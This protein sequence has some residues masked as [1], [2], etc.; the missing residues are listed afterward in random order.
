MNRIHPT[1]VIGPDVE[2][3]EGNVVGPYAV[4][5]GPAR[6][7]DGNWIGPHVVV[8]T[9]GEVRGAPHRAAW[10]DP[11]LDPA[12][13]GPAEDLGG[14]VIGNNNVL[15]EFA[16][17]QAPFVD[18]TRIG[19]DCYLMTK[20]HVPHDGVLGDRV[21]VACSVMI[22]GH[23]RIGDGA[24]LGL[25]SVLHQ[26]LVVGPGAMVG[27]GS[28]VTRP[29]PPFG[30]AYG[31]PARVRG[32]NGVGMRRSGI[33]DDVIDELASAYAAGDPEEL[34]P[35]ESL[36]QAFEWYRSALSAVRH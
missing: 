31:S 33:A 7:G 24:N 19:D 9:P 13:P 25:G 28:V 16:T 21:T 27:M 10:E 22:G 20:S 17:V 36:V 1:A 14:I 5:L 2:L 18:E 8:G 29:I 35:P 11:A 30:M 32:V 23:G 15:R 34:K 3:G 4:L 12:A 26:Y 6:I